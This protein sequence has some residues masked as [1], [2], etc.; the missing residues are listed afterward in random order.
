MR[1][2][3]EALP[4]LQFVLEKLFEQREGYH[5]TRRSYDMHSVDCRALW[6]DTRIVRLMHFP[7]I[8]TANT[9]VSSLHNTLF[10]SQ[11]PVMNYPVK[12]R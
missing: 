8:S 1:E 5:L 11:N 10:I 3:P 9:H 7:L 2:R 6:M 12:I 4:L